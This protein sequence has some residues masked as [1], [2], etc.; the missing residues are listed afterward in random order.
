VL[1]PL[2]I[3]IGIAVCGA[4]L[5]GLSRAGS[6]Y[7]IGRTLAGAPACE[8]ADVAEAAR[9]GRAYVRVHGRIASDEE[10]PDENERPL[11]Y[12]RRRLDLALDPAGR[13]WRTLEDEVH[14]VPFG[15][16]HA[17]TYV[18]IHAA[19]LDDGLVVIVRESLGTAADAPERVPPGT[20][21]ETPLRHRV[22][23]VSAVE[24]AHVAGR[25]TIDADGTAA[26]GKGGGR[27]LI[28]TTVE[29]PE[30]MRLLAAGHRGL[31]RTATV[32]LGAGVVAI[33]LGVLV[34]LLDIVSG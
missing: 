30:A 29:L 21:P 22:Q 8:L 13:A 16:E 9:A 31:V 15:I 3:A 26:L 20:P 25:P 12:R 32:G 2:L 33:V 18:A 10:F 6:G 24:H 28:L 5:F 17:G 19:D 14:A 4:A 11:V 7:R 27:P 1:P 34:G 23:Q